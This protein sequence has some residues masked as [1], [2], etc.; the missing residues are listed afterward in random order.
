MTSPEQLPAQDP[1]FSLDMRRPPGAGAVEV[2]LTGELDERT[3]EHL[4]DGLSWVFAHGE[5]AGAR[6]RLAAAGLLA[7]PSGG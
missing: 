6:A 3:V 4:V 2:L 7:L 5:S 1:Y